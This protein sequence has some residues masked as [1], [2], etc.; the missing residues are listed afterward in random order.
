MSPFVHLHVHSHYSL[1]DGLPK[2][3]DLV[4]AAKAR[5]F[6]A[7]ALTDHGNMYG[8]IEFYQECEKQGIKPIIGVETYLALNGRFEKDPNNRYRHLILLALNETGYRNL[9][10]LVSLGNTEG[11]YYKPRIDKE[12]LRQYHEG[13]VGSSAC[14]GGEIAHILRKENDWEKAKKV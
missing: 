4:K 3:K 7:L 2:I 12:L 14:F 5:G 11:F 9:M 1:L 8:A 13:L 6:S 10:K